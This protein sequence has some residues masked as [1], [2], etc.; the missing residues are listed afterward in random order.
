[1]RSS[2][3]MLDGWGCRYALSLVRCAVM[4]WRV[5]DLTMKARII[6]AMNGYLVK[7][8]EESNLNVVSVQEMSSRGW[9]LTVGSRNFFW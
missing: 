7:S 9:K 5:V 6:H 8:R 2:T 4:Q 3:E 1:V